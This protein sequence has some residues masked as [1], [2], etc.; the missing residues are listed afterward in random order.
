MTFDEIKK[1][2]TEAYNAHYVKHYTA[3]VNGKK[4][5][6]RLF[7]CGNDVYMYI[8]GSHR[9]GTPLLENTFSKWSNLIPKGV[10]DDAKETLWK[11][12]N[13]VSKML[14]KS[15]LWGEILVGTN[16]LIELGKDELWTLYNMDFNAYHN[17]LSQKGINWFGV[18]CFHSLTKTNSIKSI[19]YDKY[20]REYHKVKVSKMISD[21]VNDEIRWNGSYDYRINVSKDE[22]DNTIIKGWFSEEYHGT[23]NG[24]YYFLLDNSH[25]LFAEND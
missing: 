12:I 3:I 4:E 15:G 2:V 11:N 6:V 17:Y 8:K 24:H 16:K 19:P 20:E 23:G 9:Y 13:K 10:G 1:I 7:P 21:G 14:A 22:A 18:D 5:N 25:A